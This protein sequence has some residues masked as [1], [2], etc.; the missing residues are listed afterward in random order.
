MEDDRDLPCHLLQYHN[1]YAVW[2]I[3]EN[4][5]V[6]ATSLRRLTTNIQQLITFNLLFRYTINLY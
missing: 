2:G 3:I 1:R 6:T 5:T 4:V